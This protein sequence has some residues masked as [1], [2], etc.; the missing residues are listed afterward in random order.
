MVHSTAIW[1]VLEWVFLQIPIGFHLSLG[2]ETIA[3]SRDGCDYSVHSLCDSHPHPGTWLR[4]VLMTCV[5][6]Q[7]R[8]TNQTN[9]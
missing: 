4:Y 1:P 5:E 6:K 7:E 2:L 9:K 8:K 3:L